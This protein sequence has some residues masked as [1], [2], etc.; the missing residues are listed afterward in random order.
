MKSAPVVVKAG[1]FQS[2]KDMWLDPETFYMAEIVQT[3]E[4][5][6][7]YFIKLSHKY[8]AGCCLE[9]G[10]WTSIHD[11]EEWLQKFMEKKDA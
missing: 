4:S 7:K 9:V 10:K 11:A 6:S 3:N 2:C 1:V 5:Y 8:I